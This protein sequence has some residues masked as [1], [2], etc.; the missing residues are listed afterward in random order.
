MLRKYLPELHHD[1]IGM[2]PSSLASDL[3]QETQ[4]I[5]TE[6]WMAQATV[7]HIGKSTKSAAM[8]SIRK[9]KMKSSTKKCRMLTINDGA[10][11]PETQTI[12]MDK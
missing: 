5:I 4:A 12:Y 11:F 3:V 7:P 1:L 10:V 6:M 2:F 8:L 9:R